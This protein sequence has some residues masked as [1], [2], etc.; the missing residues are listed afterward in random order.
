M[1]VV[2]A[3]WLVLDDFKLLRRYLSEN[4]SV[5]IYYV[6]SVF[7]GV[8]VKAVV[9][10]FVRSSSGMKLFDVS[11]GVWRDS[12]VFDL[13]NREVVWDP[14]W[15]GDMVRFMTPEWEMF[16][17]SGVPLSCLFDI[18]FAARSTEYK[19]L[20]KDGIVTKLKPNPTNGI[21]MRPV[22]T[23]RNLSKGHIDYNTCYSGLW[24]HPDDVG[25]IRDFYTVPHLVVGHTKGTQLICAVDKGGYAWRE[26]FHLVPNKNFKE[27]GLDLYYVCDYLNSDKIQSYL[28]S[29]YR[30]IVPHLTKSMLERVPVKLDKPATMGYNKRME[31]RHV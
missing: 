2:P 26:K 13:T 31:V 27:Q 9:F 16:E 7:S 11:D 30:W 22:L 28:M 24:V 19:E 4:G 17:L 8:N 23:G 1:F 12:E 5:E 20:Q 18:R 14:F 10:K 29:V 6:G 25:S 15:V 21:E 3:S